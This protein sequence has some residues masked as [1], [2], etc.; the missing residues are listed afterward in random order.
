MVFVQNDT[1]YYKPSVRSN[2]IKIIEAENMY[3]NVGF[4]DFI[5]E[6]NIDQMQIW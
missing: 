4:C 1:L 6:S 2:A 5:Y 3:Q